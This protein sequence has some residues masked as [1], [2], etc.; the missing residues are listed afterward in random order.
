MAATVDGDLDYGV[1]F[2]GQSIG[3]VET[4]LSV[5]QVIQNTIREAAEVINSFPLASSS[6][7]IP[8]MPPMVRALGHVH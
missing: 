4:I 7:D 1:Q 6:G 8:S 5:D 3:Q 2:V